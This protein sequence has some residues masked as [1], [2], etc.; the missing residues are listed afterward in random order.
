MAGQVD[1]Y[2]KFSNIELGK[3][4]VAWCSNCSKEFS[5]EPKSG[6]QDED[7]ILRL[8]AKYDQHECVFHDRRA[9]L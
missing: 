3:R 1:R 8:R 9:D 4:F 6:E 7:R 5:A 2:L